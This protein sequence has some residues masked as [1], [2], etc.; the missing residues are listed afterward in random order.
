LGRVAFV[1]GSDLL[2]EQYRTA[3]RMTELD[4]RK[5]IA[6][7]AGTEDAAFCVSRDGSLVA[8]AGRNKVVVSSMGGGRARDFDCYDQVNAI[9]ISDDN[10]FV[11]MCGARSQGSRPP[12]GFVKVCNLADRTL[13]YGM[14]FPEGPAYCAAFSARD[15]LLLI[16]TGNRLYQYGIHRSGRLRVINVERRTVDHDV[17]AHLGWVSAVAASADGSRVF[18]AGTDGT[19]RMWD[20][21]TMSGPKEARCSR[22]VTGL[23]VSPAG[24]LVVAAARDGLRAYDDQLNAEFVGFLPTGGWR[25]AAFDRTGS[26]LVT[27][28]DANG[29]AIWKRD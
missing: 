5:V 12:T 13:H 27:A 18:S 22:E 10:R 8:S 25:S 28:S 6:E 23:A 1:G 9:A 16:G 17:P 15:G 7:I 20:I 26:R 4:T 29:I 14:E 21:G 11:A 19:L 3:L 24:G 2:L